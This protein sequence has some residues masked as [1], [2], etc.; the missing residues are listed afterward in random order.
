MSAH[1]RLLNLK[2]LLTPKVNDTTSSNSSDL[3]H[4][5]EDLVELAS[6]RVG[7]Q[8]VYATD[9]WFAS[10][11]NLIA[12]GEPTFIPG[13]FTPHGKWMDGWESRRKRIPGHDWCI[14]KL[15][16]PGEIHGIIA[17]TRYFTGNN[18]L[19]FSVQ[20]VC[21][22]KS[23][24]SDRI[25]LANELISERLQ[26][27]DM[28]GTASSPVLQSRV[29][30]LESDK[31]QDIV[32]F[33]H[34]GHGYEETSITRCPILDP[35]IRKQGQ[36]WTH[37]RINMFPDGGI[38]RIRVF[39]IV[40]PRLNPANNFFSAKNDN[41]I[42]NQTQN[43]DLLAAVNGGM[44]IAHSDAH[45]GSASNL[46]APGDAS[47]MGEGWETARK[48]DRPAVIQESKFDSSSRNNKSG[49]GKHER[50][51]DWA[52]LA[53]GVPG[54]VKQVVVDTKH[55]KGNFPETCFIESCYLPEIAKLG[56]LVAKK[57]FGVATHGG[58]LSPAVNWKPL[59]SRVKLSAH[60]EHVFK[61]MHNEPITHVRVTIYP[62]GG[63]SRLRLMGVPM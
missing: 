4:A 2:A 11:D 6:S 21:W 48:P 23:I 29:A 54:V 20:G 43:I 46:N 1:A 19:R 45:Y 18:A 61:P 51:R 50:W 53:L 33:T 42:K 16:M 13:K 10:A 34:L 17:N 52:V 32:P 31:W 3:S 62:D 49:M 63:I 12:S 37:I 40:L 24:D 60:Q 59:V 8:V 15:G 14:L 39:G 36:G 57:T 28:I 44:A 47:N 41:Q 35:R 5:F 26:K 55:F 7:G 38:A 58:D 9:E 25:G 27:G 30:L 56:P 22:D